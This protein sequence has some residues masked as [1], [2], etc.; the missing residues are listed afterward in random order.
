MECPTAVEY[1]SCGSTTAQWIDSYA[2]DW[3]GR[4]AEFATGT[5]LADDGVCKLRRS[6]DGINRACVYAQR[7]AYTDILI[8]HCH[9]DSLWFAVS[10]IDCACAAAKQVC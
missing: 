1:C 10:R 4:E 7:T 8:N 9:G 5:F 3:T 6:D 2:V